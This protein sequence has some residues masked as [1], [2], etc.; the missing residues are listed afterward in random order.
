MTAV[1]ATTPAPER[2]WTPPISP[3]AYDRRVTLSREERRALALIA[4]RPGR[5]PAGVAEALARFTAPVNDVL[6]VAG[7]KPGSWAGAPT[8]GDLLQAIGRE[9]IAFWGWDRAQWERAI[10]LGNVDVRQLLIAVAYQLCAINDLHWEIRGFKMRLFCG[11]VFGHAAVEETVGRVQSHLDTLGYAA[12]LRRPNLQRALYELMLAARSPVL[13]DLAERPELLP[14]IRDRTTHNPGRSGVEQLARTLVDMGV[15]SVLPFR[16]TDTRRVA[17][18]QPSRRPGRAGAVAGLREAVVSDLDADA[19]Q[20][21][22][23]VLRAD[24]ARPLDQ[25]R[26]ARPRRP[27]LLDPGARRRVGRARGPGCSSASTRTART[28]PTCAAGPA[29]NCCRAPR[30]T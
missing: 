11:R 17:R 25:P 12:Q 15:L 1:A 30:R 4:D 19:L 26:A 9:R 28:P 16:Q 20:P 5:W 14:E 10:R 3:A 21:L 13:D 7:L 18:S 22:A 8:R 27:Q 6:A 29:G 2:R 23:N 24:Q